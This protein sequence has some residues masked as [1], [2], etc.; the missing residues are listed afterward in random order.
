MLVILVYA[1]FFVVI[2]KTH[3]MRQHG[4]HEDK[5]KRHFNVI[6]YLENL[7]IKRN[8]QKVFLFIFP[9]T[10]QVVVYFMISQIFSHPL[11]SAVQDFSIS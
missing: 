4:A 5:M 2:P 11:R 10:Q 1:L 6:F 3:K 8:L 7:K 9:Q